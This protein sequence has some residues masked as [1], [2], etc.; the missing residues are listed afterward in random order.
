MTF[1]LAGYRVMDLILNGNKKMI[2]GINQDSKR[3]TENG[4]RNP[5]EECTLET[6]EN[7]G[8]LE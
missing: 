7:I 2:F 8:I 5:V 1:N 3:R 6:E 4:K